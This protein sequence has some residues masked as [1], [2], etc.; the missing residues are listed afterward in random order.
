M[1]RSYKIRLPKTEPHSM[2]QDEAFFHLEEEGKQTKI[3]FH[4]YGAIYRRRGLYEQLFYDRLKCLSP[5][6]VKHMLQEVLAENRSEASELRVLDLGAGNGMVGEELAAL[7]VARIVGVDVSR[8][9]SAACE[10]DRP[11]IYD[12]YYVEDLAYVEKRT[13]DDLKA[14]QFDCLTCVAA[15]G[16]G[17]IPPAAFGNAFNLV[18]DGGWIAFNVKETF[19]Q[20][21]DET[22][23]S[24]L[25]K[26]LLV[27]DTL[28]LHHLER[29]RHRISIDG[30]P[31]YYY[32]VVGKKERDIPKELYADLR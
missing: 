27:T 28:E 24:T 18:S 1:K 19:L 31:L 23:F 8:D 7:G 6:K 12:A 9:A 15:L 26:Q 4:D 32:A 10:R 3:R 21:S 11:G 5:A 22:G 29:Y 16:F 30:R 2:D 13:F 25:V 20:S 17:D 14:W